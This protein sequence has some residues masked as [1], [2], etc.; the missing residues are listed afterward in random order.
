MEV[1]PPRI[2]L[3]DDLETNRFLLEEALADIG[4]EIFTADSGTRALDMLDACR[5]D[6]V[7]LD[8]QMPELNGAETARRIKQAE[9]SGA[10]FT[11]VILTSGYREAEDAALA[12]GLL[13]DRFLGKP[14]A[15]D[16]LRSLVGEGLRVARERRAGMAAVTS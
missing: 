16:D 7:L 13:A 1:A 8:F 11:F 2:L 3:V 5:P 14:Y 15:L 6:V 12:E 10:P 4:A 9:Q